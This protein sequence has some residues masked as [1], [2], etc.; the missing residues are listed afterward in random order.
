MRRDARTGEQP[1]EPDRA[2]E[3]IDPAM[4]QTDMDPARRP[5]DLPEA[6]IVTEDDGAGVAGGTHGGSGGGSTMPGHPDA[7]D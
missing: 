2:E 7:A 6:D 5:R 1:V 4:T 3:D